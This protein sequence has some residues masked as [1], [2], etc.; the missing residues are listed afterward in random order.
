M[1]TYI[2]N[3]SGGADLTIL[4][5]DFND[6]CTSKTYEQ[7]TSAGFKDADGL[8]EVGKTRTATYG[9]PENTNDPGSFGSHTL[10]F[11]FLKSHR[12]DL[13]FSSKQMVKDKE[14]Q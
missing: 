14:F 1:L 11:I 10:D 13:K 12:E 4:G 8:A 9:N 5:G 6:D 7:I 2:E 3:T